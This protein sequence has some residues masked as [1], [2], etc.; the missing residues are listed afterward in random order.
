[1]SVIVQCLGFIALGF[2]GR[3]AIHP[4][5]LRQLLSNLTQLP[6]RVGLKTFR[7][8][9][10]AWGGVVRD[11]AKSLARRQSGLLQRSLKVKVKIPDAS[12]NA[13][14]HGK[15]A[16]VLVGPDRNV[17]GPVSRGRLFGIR[18]ATKF[19][20]GG[21]RVQTRRPSRYAHLIE[22]GT[23]SHAIK[24]TRGPLAGQTIQHHGT[25]AHPFIGPAQRHGNTV[26][27]VKFQQKLREGI[28]KEAAA[29]AR[30]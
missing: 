21:G 22:R 12:Y 5:S 1:M 16:Y 20:L 30:K 27:M 25:Q 2:I 15:P 3:V 14:H 8:A 26:G 29:L 7:I 4:V 10:N 19:V 17:V 18:K 24:I 9:L 6:R 23:K 13:K 11:K 28:E